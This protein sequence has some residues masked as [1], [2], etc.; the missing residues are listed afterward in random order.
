MIKFYHIKENILPSLIILMV[1]ATIIF[2][3]TLIPSYHCPHCGKEVESE[4]YEYNYCPRCGNK[5]DTTLM[6]NIY[7]KPDKFKLKQQ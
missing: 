2:V 6:Y 5:L 3:F 4:T 1:E 7:N